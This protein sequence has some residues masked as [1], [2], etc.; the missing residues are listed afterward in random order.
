M[1]LEHLRGWMAGEHCLVVAPGPS[2]YK[3]PAGRYSSH[4]TIG[5]NRAVAFCRPDFA[6]CVEPITDRDCWG[7]IGAASP[8]VVFAHHDKR[9]PRVVLFDTDLST[10]MNTETKLRLGMSPFY[11]AAVA[12]ALGFTRIGLIGVDL[13]G[14]PRFRNEAFRESCEVAWRR[15]V[16]VAADAGSALVNLN[17][18]SK[19]LAV[20]KVGWEG[21]SRK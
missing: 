8:M 9:H 6:V 12:V 2:A 17:P 4:W 5:C 19:L 15:L 7:T 11:G 16:Q 14:K 10:W 1:Q 3:T 21:M 18:R 13:D 20:P